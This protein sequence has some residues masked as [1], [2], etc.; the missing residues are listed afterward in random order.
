MAKEAKIESVISEEFPEK[1]GFQYW[2]LLSVEVT[3]E[4]DR[5]P[6]SKE[7]AGGRL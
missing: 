4:D 6:R 2:N 1:V 7:R 3:R 5:A